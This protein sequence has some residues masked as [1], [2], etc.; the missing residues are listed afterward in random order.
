[1][2][3]LAVAALVLAAVVALAPSA[4]ATP[5]TGGPGPTVVARSFRVV[6]HTPDG[7]W[8]GSYEGARRYAARRGTSLARRPFLLE[9]DG[10]RYFGREPGYPGAVETRTFAARPEGYSSAAELSSYVEFVLAQARGGR[11]ALVATTV[12]GRPAWRASLGL[13]ANDCAGLARGRATVWLARRTLL[14]LRL[15][16]TRGQVVRRFRYSYR[17][18]NGDLPASDFARPRLGARPFREDQ[19]FRRA[20]PAAAAANLSY[21]P[22][23]PTTLPRGFRFT[24]SGWAPRSGLTGAEGSNPRYA[25]LFA[26]VYRRGTERIDVSQRLA[27]RRGWLADPFGGECLFEYVEPARV[28]GAIGQYGIGAEIVPHLYWREGRVIYTVSGPFPKRDLL[29][30]AS[31]LTPVP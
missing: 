9:R 22:E 27:G 6:A 8:L 28:R 18:V 14:T 24:A 3:P 19:G 26:A 25:Q 7:V 1:V 13:H 23:L 5:F 15:V 2:R 31:S 20:G 4:P 10:A 21:A 16:T 11:R 17:A 30:V 29:A 12:A